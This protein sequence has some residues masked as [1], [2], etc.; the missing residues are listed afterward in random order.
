MPQ[1]SA[2]DRLQ[3][4]TKKKQI[5]SRMRADIASTKALNSVKK[6]MQD[7]RIP[8]TAVASHSRQRLNR[9]ETESM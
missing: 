4:A 1:I 5:D 8:A 6:C 3:K 9:A 2:Q 7:L